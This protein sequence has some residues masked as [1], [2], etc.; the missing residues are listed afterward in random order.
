VLDDDQG[1]S[2]PSVYDIV[3]E[4]YLQSHFRSIASKSLLDLPAAKKEYK[5]FARELQ[6]TISEV[7]PPA[8]DTGTADP[9]YLLDELRETHE[10]LAP[11]QYPHI[12]MLNSIDP[13]NAVRFYRENI[14]ESIVK[15]LEKLKKRKII[16]EGLCSFLTCDNYLSPLSS[17]PVNG[18]LTLLFSRPFQR[19]YEDAY[20]LNKDS[21]EPLSRRAAAIYNNFSDILFEQFR[22]DPPDRKALEIKTKEM[23]FQWNVA[24]TRLD[25]CLQIAQMYIGSLG[26]KN[27]HLG[28]DGLDYKIT[29]IDS[30]IELLSAEV[31]RSILVE[32]STPQI[33]KHVGHNLYCSELMDDPFAS[34]RPCLIFNDM[35]WR[36]DFITIEEIL[37]KLEL[38]L[39]EYGKKDEKVKH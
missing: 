5:N 12:E 31:T 24:S 39:E 35:G 26:T 1:V 21:F 7:E 16:T 14:H 15:G 37:T 13:L 27:Y 34:L 6:T 30:N 32:G 4:Y 28:I 9:I 11:K 2:G 10:E 20:L 17:Y 29:D 33:F 19:I 18:T 3:A 38:K 22:S 23:I 25:F 36:S 8:A